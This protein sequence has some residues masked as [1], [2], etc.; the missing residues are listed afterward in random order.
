MSSLIEGLS[1]DVFLMCLSRLPLSQHPGLSL[2]CCAWRAAVQS[3][4]LLKTRQEVNF[5]EDFICVSAEEPNNVWQLYDPRENLWITIP[6]LPSQIH[7]ISYFSAVSVAGKLFVLGG[8]HNPKTLEEGDE[9]IFATNEV[10]SY[11]PVTKK[12]AICAPMVTPRIMFACGV[13]N[14]KIVVAG[15]FDASRN[16]TAKAETYDPENNVWNLM[17][18]LNHTNDSLCHGVVVKGKMHVVHMGFPT[19]Q[20]FDNEE[21]AWRTDICSWSDNPV[22]VVQDEI[23]VKS[24]HRRCYYNRNA[25]HKSFGFDNKFGSGMA[26]LGNKICIFGGVEK[27]QTPYGLPF[28][29]SDVTVL[30]FGRSGPPALGVAAPMTRCRGIILAC[31]SMRV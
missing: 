10:W 25:E 23:Y 31:T 21:Q 14:G 22:V 29:N 18:D 2:V 30:R 28:P 7:H 9:G 15:G 3:V 1:D 26:S 6:T 27:N 24:Y 17:P 13:V 12:W 16:P 19:V 8:G 4:E 20:K 11:E 5:T